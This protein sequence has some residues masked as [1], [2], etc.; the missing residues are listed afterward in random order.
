MG[1]EGGKT[2]KKGDDIGSTIAHPPVGAIATNEQQ[3]DAFWKLFL[4]L[5]LFLNLNNIKKQLIT[6][7][8]NKIKFKTLIIF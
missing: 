5:F 6:L 3:N 1:V 4:F 8:V 7:F 2:L